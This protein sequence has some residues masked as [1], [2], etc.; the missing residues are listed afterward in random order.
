MRCRKIEKLLSNNID[1]ELPEKK[2]KILETHLRKCSSCSSYAENIER[3]HKQ[4]KN[5]ERLEV[6][7]IY[8]EEFTS[9]IKTEIS[10]VQQEKRRGPPQFLR[11]KW[12][13]AG[14][15]WLFVIVVGL[16]LYLTQNKTP[17]EVYV[18]SFE[19]SLAK[20]YQEI[21]SDPEL[22]ELFN[23]VILA[24]LGELLGDSGWGECP[25]FHENLILWENLTEEEMRYLE[26]E[27]KKDN[28][29]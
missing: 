26:S 10:Y 23:S 2:N 18:F 22:E 28:K 16:F 20:I 11:R 9:R 17:Q 21:G 24:S 1:G 8:W 27:I 6:S 14:A 29:L 25:D 3:I 19:N 15:A 5:L 7:P 13:W 4:A 12:V